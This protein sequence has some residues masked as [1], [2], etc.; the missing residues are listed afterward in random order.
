MEAYPY[1]L[2]YGHLP[3]NSVRFRTTRN[4]S[5]KSSNTLRN[6]YKKK[7][8]E[9]EG[10]ATWQQIRDRGEKLP[11]ET[12]PEGKRIAEEISRSVMSGI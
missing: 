11:R 9:K 7:I 4:G 5:D 1:G 10:S 2:S 8:K 12:F 6:R 3:L